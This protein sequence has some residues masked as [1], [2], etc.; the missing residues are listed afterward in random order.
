MKL[1]VTDITVPLRVGCVGGGSVHAK[2]EGLLYRQVAGRGHIGNR[3]VGILDNKS[4]HANRER[5]LRV[6]G[7]FA[8]IPD[9]R[10]VRLESH[11]GRKSVCFASGRLTNKYVDCSRCAFE[12]GVV[13][14]EG[15]IVADLDKWCRHV[16]SVGQGH[17]QT[18]RLHISRES[19]AF[20]CRGASLSARLLLPSLLPSLCRIFLRGGAGFG[21]SFDFGCVQVGLLGAFLGARGL[22]LF[23]LGI[24]TG[25]QNSGFLGQIFRDNSS[26]HD[27]ISI[28]KPTGPCRGERCERGKADGQLKDVGGRT[29]DEFVDGSMFVRCDEERGREEIRKTVVILGDDR[30]TGSCLRVDDEDAY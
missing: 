3:R 6:V 25:L 11:V 24:L 23:S 28:G 10:G 29:H 5:S 15:G 16:H 1:V 17:T 9:V 19:R 7:F 21:S 2:L 27:R 30:P 20:G 26:N 8:G 22:L 12:R 13:P 14:A 18:A 4:V